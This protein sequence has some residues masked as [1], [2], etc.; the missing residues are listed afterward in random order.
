MLNVMKVKYIHF[1][2]GHTVSKWQILDF[3]TLS[4]SRAQ[5]FFYLYDTNFDWAHY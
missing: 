3:S 5:D 2:Q 4:D 1:A